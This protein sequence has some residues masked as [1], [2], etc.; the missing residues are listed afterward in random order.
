MLLIEF[1][2][3]FLYREDCYRYY[4]VEADYGGWF[5]PSAFVYSSFDQFRR[6][7]EGFNLTLRPGENYK[8]PRDIFE[9]L[10]W[11]ID[12]V[13]PAHL[14][15]CFGAIILLKNEE[16]LERINSCLK[17]GQNVIA[18]Y[19]A[20]TRYYTK[21]STKEEIDGFFAAIG[22]S[23]STIAPETLEQIGW[24]AWGGREGW[25][26]ALA[27]W[28]CEVETSTQ[29]RLFVLLDYFLSDA[30]HFEGS[31]FLA[32]TFNTEKLNGLVREFTTLK[33]P[34]FSVVHE[35]PVSV[36][37]AHEPLFYLYRIINVG[38]S[39]SKTEVI[40]HP[41]QHFEHLTP[42]ERTLPPL[43]AGGQTSLGLQVRPLLE[44]YHETIVEFEMTQGGVPCH[45]FFPHYPLR[46]EPRFGD[47][48]RA[49]VKKD[50]SALS[51]LVSVARDSPVFDEIRV[52]PDLL[53][54][55]AASCAGKIRTVAELL[56]KRVA[57]RVGIQWP[58]NFNGAINLLKQ[59]GDISPRVASYLHTIRQIGNISVHE[60]NVTDTDVRILAYALSCVFEELIRNYS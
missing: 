35:N 37:P 17:R 52:L 45:I 32:S 43:Q 47:A 38:S 14:E 53:T 40:V 20:Y 10:P 26:D 6:F 46:V 39:T 33:Y 21:I 2:A 41:V 18:L 55:D 44:G 36:W 28:W 51:R 12:M 30:Y 4:A 22:F 58:R 57:D 34:A 25:K 27:I 42:L 13:D 1:N 5:N 24:G 8:P 59:H 50:D 49:T 11:R 60:A 48:F 7:C 3:D 56:L 29:G 54:V 31:E 9:P 16:S 15:E 23:S 19:P